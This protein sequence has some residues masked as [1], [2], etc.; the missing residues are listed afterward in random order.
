MEEK[1][2][3]KKM[4]SDMSA[5]K[6]LILVFAAAVLLIGLAVLLINLIL[7]ESFDRWYGFIIGV[8]IIMCV[9]FG[10]FASTKH[11][12][13]TD[14]IFD[15]IIFAVPYA[16]FGGT[17]Y[18]AI[19]NGGGMGIGVLGALIGAV[20]GLLIAK[21]V[22]KDMLSMMPKIGAKLIYSALFAIPISLLGGLAETTINGSASYEFGVVGLVIGAVAG[23]LLGYLVLSSFTTHPSVSM[24]QMLDL[25]C[26]FFLLGQAIGRIG[27][28]FG[29]CCYG[30]AVDFDIFPF[31]YKVHGVL[32]LANPFIESMWC[33][34]GFIP[35]AAIYLSK[36]RNFVGFQTVLYCIWYGIGRLVLEFFRA[37][38][39][40]LTI[41][42][43]FGISQLV[44]IFMIVF[45]LIYV[46]AYFILAAR[47]KKKA[48]FFVPID[49]LDSSY[50]GYEKLI[51]AS[52]VKEDGCEAAQLEEKTEETKGDSEAKE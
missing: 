12:Y 31:S 6:K 19:F 9:I 44:S 17:V 39:Q 3:I 26:S 29:G 5:V 14:M 27:C 20:I 4:F 25:A 10:Q 48:L 13:Y 32:H 47:S 42:G 28:Y 40:K 15:Y 43:N 22:Y 38:E 34:I 23:M 1:K 37:D 7:G 11:G 30:I 2:S 8:A 46:A 51:S 49:K 35:I 52:S 21:F 50:Y 45:A 24:M 33:F 41:F 18:Y 36:R 16:F